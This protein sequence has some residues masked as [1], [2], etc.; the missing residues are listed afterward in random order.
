MYKIT[1][2][3]CLSLADDDECI[4][5]TEH[6]D[7]ES[8]KDVLLQYVPQMESTLSDKDRICF[9]CFET[10][11]KFSELIDRCIEIEE[12]LS[13]NQIIF[14]NVDSEEEDQ[15]EEN[16][17]CDADVLS[18]KI[19]GFDH[20]HDYIK[21]DDSYLTTNNDDENQFEEFLDDN[22]GEETCENSIETVL[23]PGTPNTS[24]LLQEDSTLDSTDENNLSPN[25]A[26]AASGDEIMDPSIHS[27][28]V[29]CL[30]DS[31][32]D[33]DE[34]GEDCKLN[35]K[36]KNKI[37]CQSVDGEKITFYESC[38]E[39]DNS[40]HA[41]ENKIFY[42]STNGKFIF[43]ES[44][45]RETDGYICNACGDS[46]PSQQ[47]LSEH[48]LHHAE[49]RFMCDKCPRIFKTDSALKAH[50]RLKHTAYE[51]FKC[52][53]CG[54][55]FARGDYLKNHEKHHVDSQD[56]YNLKCKT[57]GKFLRFKNSD[58]PVPCKICGK[59]YNGIQKLKVHLQTHLVVK[60]FKC[61]YCD[62]TYKR[63]PSLK[64]HEKTHLESSTTFHRCN[65][66]WKR[67]STKEELEL[68]ITQHGNP[69]YRC[70]VCDEQFHRKYLF[71]DHY[72]MKH[73][74]S[75][76]IENS[77]KEVIYDTLL[78]LSTHKELT[79]EY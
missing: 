70:Q 32:M 2:R 7:N 65:V 52:N 34:V 55:M 39:D 35:E 64:R 76:D 37:I 78:E 13:N 71:D 1:C 75:E 31:S 56:K 41:D 33:V 72:L 40:D 36:G 42:S 43:Y 49:L 67:F 57:P 15:N 44:I 54:Q 68:H 9:L 59:Y 4:Q 11:K 8:I 63:W 74:T 51:R 17:N 48:Y 18:T 10:L 19:L 26:L 61:N 22:Q 12:Q 21:N 16:Y 79:E 53:I 47:I 38:E 3:T 62:L 66:C 45:K 29:E 30:N 77:K 23:I 46:F 50:F 58:D 14:E 20:D 28:K 25:I 69:R 27:L 5:I 60:R 73:A 24:K 6:L